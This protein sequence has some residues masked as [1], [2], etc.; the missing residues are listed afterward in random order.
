VELDRDG[1]AAVSEERRPRRADRHKP[2]VTE[3][4]EPQGY[5]ATKRSSRTGKKTRQAESVGRMQEAAAAVVRKLGSGLAVAVAAAVGL[6][7]ALGLVFLAINGINAAARWAAKRQADRQASAAAAQKARGNLLV[8]ATQDKQATGFLAMRVDAKTSRVFG[9]AIP[10]GAFVEVPG[11][12]FERIGDSYKAGPAV[13]LATVSN[14]LSVPFDYYVT[15]DDAVYKG[16]LKQQDVSTLMA[17]VTDTN[18]TSGQRADLARTLGQVTGKNV[19]LAPLPVRSVSIGSMTYYEPQ[20]D[21]IADLLYSWWGVRLG[22]G[23]QTPRVIIYNGSGNPGIAGL[24]ARQLIKAGFRVVDT[25]NADRFD[26]ATTQIVLLRGA[27]GEADR[28]RD[29]LGVGEVVHKI[30]DEDI[31]DVVVIVGRDYKPPAS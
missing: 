11:Q 8:I 28:V 12:G 4:E 9:I 2:P 16:M 27:A 29:I 18:L 14:Y 22:S 26:Y 23:A 6:A 17:A 25:G 21:Q 15:V 3:R 1:G 5:R 10:D 30:A 7:L 31:T 19:G 13:S 20:R 24:A